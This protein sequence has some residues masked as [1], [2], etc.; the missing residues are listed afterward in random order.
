MRGWYVLSYRSDVPLKTDRPIH[1]SCTRHEPFLTR[2]E[3]PAHECCACC[4]VRGDRCDYPATSAHCLFFDRCPR[5]H[6]RLCEALAP[7]WTADRS[8]RGSKRSFCSRN[9][10]VC[11]P[12]ECRAR[13]IRSRVSQRCIPVRHP[14]AGRHGIVGGRRVPHCGSADHRR[15][16]RSSASDRIG[17]SPS[18][19]LIARPACT[20]AAGSP[21]ELHRPD[22]LDGCD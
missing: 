2:K 3:Q 10:R 22:T 14:P 8:D 11:T 19:G 5:S 1:S 17:G 9:P 12:G 6:C 13:R 7:H 18:S 20:Q 21:H 15:P 16:E 4:R